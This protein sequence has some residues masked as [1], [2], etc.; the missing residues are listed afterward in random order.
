MTKVYLSL[1]SNIERY[2][3]ISAAL[4]ALAEQFGE[5]TISPVY[6]S[7]SVGFEG[8][9]FLNL[10][11]AMDTDMPVGVLSNALRE[12]E[13]D[14]GRVR[15][16][17]K[18]SARTLDIDILTYGTEV[19]VIDGVELPRDEITKYG[20]VITP[21]VDIAANGV[22]PGSKKSYQTIA[23]ELNL[24]EKEMWPVEFRW[25]GDAAL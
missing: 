23:T 25:P 20:F 19:G 21:L 18:F 9:N 12:I 11:V 1:G 8:D 17:S 2:K 15:A 7:V 3:N 24:D 6:E 14:N 4:N 22:L 10:V 5:L 13:N 16:A